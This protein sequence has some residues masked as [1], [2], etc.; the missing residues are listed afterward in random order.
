VGLTQ[1][2]EYSLIASVQVY[3]DKK[4]LQKLISSYDLF[5]RRISNEFARR[6]GL[7]A[8]D[9][10][11]EGLVG[12]ITSVKKFDIETGNRLS[13]YAHHWIAQAARDYTQNNNKIEN[14]PVRIPVSARI[15]LREYRAYLQSNG[16]DEKKLSLQQIKDIAKGLGTTFDVISSARQTFSVSARVPID[17][18]IHNSEDNSQ[19]YGD[20]LSDTSESAFDI[21][22][23]QMGKELLTTLINDAK[24][25]DRER[26]IF[27]R[28]RLYD[29]PDTLEIL[30]QEY[31]V[32][33]ERIRQIEEKALGKLRRAVKFY[34][35]NFIGNENGRM[36]ELGIL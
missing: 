24:L 19:T 32:S 7:D 11:Q 5:I 15:K 3:D 6:S 26:D 29:E 35:R 1:D 13:T 16:L 30:A 14:V 28:R 20:F 33:R 10:Y 27:A 31:N 36:N 8:E 2:E 17:A 34:M 18:P 4:A 25:T 23:D 9:V 22:N 12:F 21:L